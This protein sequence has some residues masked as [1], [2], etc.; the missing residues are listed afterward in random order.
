M[1][2][3][4]ENTVKVQSGIYNKSNLR[5]IEYTSRLL[6]SRFS[7]PGTKIRFGLD[8]VLSLFPVLGDLFTT[9]VSGVLIYAMYT[10]GASGNVV[11]RMILNSM[12]DAIIGAIP[13]IGTVFDVFYRANDRNVRL[14]KEHYLEGKYQGSGRGLLTIV[15][16]AALVVIGAVSYGMWQL[17]EYLL[18]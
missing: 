11:I 18:R 5:W 17:I 1:K 10:R 13:V 2:Y 9:I 7:V 6:D 15:I 3:S 12:L 16:I 4:A 8:P 14:L